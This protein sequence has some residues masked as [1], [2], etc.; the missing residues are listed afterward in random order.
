MN[1]ARIRLR[2]IEKEDSVFLRDLANDPVVRANV[3]GWD[4]PISLTG[5]TRW[6]ESGA[7]TAT[8][9]RFIIETLE[10]VPIGLTGLWDIDWRNRSAMSAIKLGSDAQARGRGYGVEAIR[11]LMDFAFNDVGLN[12]LHGS[13]LDGN[14]ASLAVYIRKSG[15]TLEGRLRQHIWR[16]GDFIDLLQVG[17]LRS[18][19]ESFVD[20]AGRS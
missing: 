8:T 20:S 15:W 17:I 3:V 9:R 7:E 19:Y 6:F 1:E 11:V 2:P 18:E 13:I 12:R 4:W 10:G 5:Q 16:N 14:E